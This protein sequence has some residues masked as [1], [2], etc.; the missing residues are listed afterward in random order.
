MR[1]LVAMDEFKDIISSYQ[2]N[3]Y[4]KKRL[5]VKLVMQILYK[6][7]YLMDVMNLWTRFFMAIRH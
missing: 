6:S 4:V 1:V 3:R 2:A 7:H 5:P